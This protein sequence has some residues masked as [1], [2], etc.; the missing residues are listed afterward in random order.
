[1]IQMLPGGLMIDP[2]IEKIS[3]TSRR[4]A[5]LMAAEAGPT[6]S[7]SI[8]LCNFQPPRRCRNSILPPQWRQASCSVTRDA[9]PAVDAA[10]CGAILI[11]GGGFSL[12]LGPRLHHKEQGKHAKT[13]QGAAG[14][15]DLAHRVAI[16][17]LGVDDAIGVVVVVNPQSSLW[18]RT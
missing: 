2:M 1:M 17:E 13:L 5:S 15:R 10:D 8:S 12:L 16:V 7:C 3:P 18:A 9:C 11:H 6:H 4:P 14:F